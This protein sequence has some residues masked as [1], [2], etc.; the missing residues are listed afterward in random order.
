MK[1][2]VA[3]YRLQFNP[4]LLFED[5]VHILEYLKELG[6]SDIYA[7]PVFLARTGSL[8]G[9]DVV[10]Q[11]EISLELGGQEGFEKLMTQIRGMGLGW[12]QDMVPNHMAFDSR[13]KMLMD[14]LEQGEQSKYCGFF[15]IDWKHPDI[16]GKIL[17]PFLGRFYGRCLE[18]K[19]I[20]LAFSS[21]GFTFDYYD[22][23]FPL[24]LK[25]YETVLGH[26][27][28][29]LR[30]KRG[31]QDNTVKSLEHL[32][33]LFRGLPSWEET[34]IRY[35]KVHEA[36]QN[37]WDLFNQDPDV[38]RYIEE[39]IS[40]FNGIRGDAESFNFL[41][42]LLQEQYFRFSFWK[43][44]TEELNY[45]RFFNINELISLKVEEEKVFNEVHSLLFKLFDTYSFTGVRV[46]HI[47]GLFDPTVYLNRLRQNLPE[48][49]VIVE[50]I[51][52]FREEIPRFWPIQGTTGYDFLNFVNSL[53]CDTNAEKRMMRV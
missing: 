19:E 43:V 2:P 40:L 25:S 38:R 51:L 32:I 53:F 12:I 5:A 20:Q 23:H 34:G 45:R 17:A 16:M 47:D 48:A 28:G 15:D 49:Y 7:S 36:K 37:L 35:E 18:D 31:P 6:I 41:D 3:T 1:I 11:R 9:Y 14:I 30:E 50:K 10:D 29:E 13:N 24:S 22:F 52:D 27:L 44:G 42:R 21:D 46:D 39:T 26:G 4:S 33:M 8:H